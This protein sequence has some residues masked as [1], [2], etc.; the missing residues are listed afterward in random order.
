MQSCSPVPPTSRFIEKH[1]ELEK[2]G[3]LDE[4]KLFEETAKALLAE[5]IVLRRRGGARM[6]L[7]SPGVSVSPE[8]ESRDPVLEMRLKDMLQELQ[9]EHREKQQTETTRDPATTQ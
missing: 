4:E 7:Q 3:D 9:Q 5:G 1:Q 6:A 8:A 2:T